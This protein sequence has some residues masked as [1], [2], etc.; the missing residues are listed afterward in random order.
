MKRL[1]LILS[2]LLLFTMSG[3]ELVREVVT[4][5][6]IPIEGES[7]VNS[8]DES[9]SQESSED[10]SDTSSDPSENIASSEKNEGSS[11]VTDTSSDTTVSGSGSSSGG[12]IDKPD[13]ADPGALSSTVPAG[14]A[15]QFSDAAKKMRDSVL[16]AKDTIKASGTTY[17]VSYKGSDSNSG[18]SPDKAW[19]TL[20]KLNQSNTKL[21]AGDAVLF[22]RGGIYRTPSGIT[23]ISGVSYGAYGSG[24]KPCV[25]GSVK[26]YA[27]ANWESLGDNLWRLNAGLGNNVG[28]IVFDHGKHTGYLRLKKSD[29]KSNYD[30][31]TA[32]GFIT[33]YLDKDPAKSFKSIEIG[34][35]MRLFDM[36]AGSKDIT[37][38]NICFKYCGGHAVRGANCSNVTVRGLEIGYVGGSI[39]TGY[40]N[41]TT[42]YGN[43]VEFMS[44]SQNI[45]VENCWIYQIYDT[46]VT[47]QGSGDYHLKGFTVKNNLIEYCGMGSIEYWHTSDCDIADVTY[48][49]NLMRFAGYGFGGTQRPDKEMTGHIMSN[50]KPTGAGYNKVAK[51][52]FFIIKNN[53][54]EL[55]T[56]QLVNATSSAGT[57]PTLDGN[58]YVQWQGKWLGYYEDINNRKFNSSVL[59]LLQDT[60]GDKNATVIFPE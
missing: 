41:G 56:Y 54:F 16:S 4:I 29:V 5:E 57:P 7:Q 15:S 49:G 25:Y 17:Y 28:I 46:G 31:Y 11:S 22:E 59:S 6:E 50:G 45:L 19:A 20:A 32:D 38:E 12:T 2:I 60:W 39:L 13:V 35:N 8:S 44:N 55:S 30:F 21:K 40:G 51:D 58:T 3:C 43:G 1:A 23:L 42:R 47:H 14:Y 36:P 10:T 18:T 37:I 27:T 34:H 52:G 48:E 53:I 9:D 24:D 33:L 26:N